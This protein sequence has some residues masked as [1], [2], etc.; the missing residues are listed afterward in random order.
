MYTETVRESI[1]MVCDS[2]SYYVQLFATCMLYN[3]YVWLVFHEQLSGKQVQTT[4]I[5]M[6]YFENA[7]LHALGT[8][9]TTS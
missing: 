8:A 5:Y 7:I 9:T 6:N 1:L 3:R 4:L 2:H